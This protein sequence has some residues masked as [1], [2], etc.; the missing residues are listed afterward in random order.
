MS[1]Y[2]GVTSAAK[3]IAMHVDCVEP[4][5]EPYMQ[6]TITAKITAPARDCDSLMPLDDV[7]AVDPEPQL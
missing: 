6:S 3:P 7:S 1:L 2:S 5:V 4:L